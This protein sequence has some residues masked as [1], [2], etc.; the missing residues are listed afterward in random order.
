MNCDCIER[1]D[2]ALKPFDTEIDVA[3]VGLQMETSLKVPTR[4]RD[5]VKPKRGEKPRSILITFCP[6]CGAQAV[7]GTVAEGATN[8]N[9]A[10]K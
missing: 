1:A 2:A 5:G 6:F 8:E 3:F 4:W 10:G 9:T 7:I